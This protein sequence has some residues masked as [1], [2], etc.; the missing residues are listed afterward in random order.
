MDDAG[1]EDHRQSAV[2]ERAQQRAQ[3]ADAGVGVRLVGTNQHHLGQL[4][5]PD[6]G[7]GQERQSVAARTVDEV[8]GAVAG[9]R[10]KQRTAVLAERAGLEDLLE[11]GLAVLQHAQVERHRSRVDT[12]YAGHMIGP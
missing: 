12:G 4:A 6:G 8:I 10:L 1:T 7:C 11:H 3:P 2:H 5:L 9:E